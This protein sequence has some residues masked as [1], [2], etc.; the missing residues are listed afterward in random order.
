VWRLT[1]Y[2]RFK[3]EWVHGGQIWGLNLTYRCLKVHL[4]P[5][6]RGSTAARNGLKTRRSEI[7]QRVF[8]QIER[9]CDA[10]N[11]C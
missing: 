5:C 3:C 11:V 6:H 1:G 10:I 8:T 4:F 2:F 7:N 9:Y